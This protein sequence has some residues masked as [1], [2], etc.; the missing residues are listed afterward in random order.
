MVRASTGLCII[1]LVVMLVLGILWTGSPKSYADAV[2]EYRTTHDCYRFSPK[3]DITPLELAL[4]MKDVNFGV[5]GTLGRI[6][7]PKSFHMD[8]KYSRNFSVCEKD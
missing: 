5:N 8:D 7:T 2:K 4:I 6:Y 1:G 3:P